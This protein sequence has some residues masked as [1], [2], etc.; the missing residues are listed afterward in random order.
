MEKSN[1]IE[2]IIYKYSSM[3]ENDF[4]IENLNLLIESLKKKFVTK[5]LFSKRLETLAW[6]K[7]NNSPYHEEKLKEKVYIVLDLIEEYYTKFSPIIEYSI[8]HILP[9]DGGDENS[10]IGNL[11]PLEFI[12]NRRCQTKPLMEKLPIYNESQLVTP[13]K[14]YSRYI[15]EEFK[16]ESRHSYIVNL[17][18]DKILNIE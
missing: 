5:S 15:K 11:L 10:K 18:Y 17:L 16:I 12:L 6:S 9:D 7:L 1:K 3:L 13:R 8:E 4:S 2:N 14:F